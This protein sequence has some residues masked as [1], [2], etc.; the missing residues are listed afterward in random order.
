MPYEHR[1]HRP[2]EVVR[3]FDTTGKCGAKVLDRGLQEFADDD[4]A[5]EGRGRIDTPEAVDG[6]AHEPL[7]CFGLRQVA[8]SRDHLNC[9]PAGLEILDQA[10]RRI[11]DD[12]IMPSVG[13]QTAEVGADI[14]PCVAD[15]R[16]PPGHPFFNSPCTT[17]NGTPRF[18]PV[19]RLW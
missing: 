17:L 1:D 12:E 15:D 2:E 6:R 10:G 19:L 13:Q 3:A 4:V 16:Y 8:G 14:E 7:G 11:T 18:V 9:R 5:R